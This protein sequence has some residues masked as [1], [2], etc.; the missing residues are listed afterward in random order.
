MPSEASARSRSRSRQASTPSAGSSATPTGLVR[1]ARPARPVGAELLLRQAVQQQEG[2]ECGGERDEDPGEYVVA[3]ERTP[4]HADRAWVERIEGGGRTAGRVVAVLRNPQE[5]DA[6]PA[7]PHIRD[8]A[9]IV[10]ERRIVPAGRARVAVRD[11]DEEREERGRPDR[12]SGPE[13]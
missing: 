3:E 8:R 5:P 4:D 13:E 2:A 11:E 1:S 7:G 9:E 10:R 6:V 12:G